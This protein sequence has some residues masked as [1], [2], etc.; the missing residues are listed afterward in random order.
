M[1]ISQDEAEVQ[2]FVE[3]A[4][5]ADQN[6][7]RNLINHIRRIRESTQK[8]YNDDVA[9]EKR[10]VSAYKQLKE[11]LES[12]NRKLERMIVQETANHKLYVKRVAE[13]IVKI[14]Q[15]RKLR[16]AK[17]AEKKATIAERLAKKKRYLADK[18]QRDEERRVIK[19]IDEIVKRRL[20]NMS[21]YLA[22]SI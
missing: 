3:L 12:D 17:I 21:K 14:A 18:A 8:S 19:R 11:L 1:Q 16:K 7:L 15:T 4:T 6:A 10:S 20:A 13:L 9:H 5:E 2:A 22:N